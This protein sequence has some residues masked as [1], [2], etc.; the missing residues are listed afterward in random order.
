V[1]FR[2]RTSVTIPAGDREFSDPVK[3]QVGATPSSKP[4]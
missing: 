4:A 1:R 2:G 3:L